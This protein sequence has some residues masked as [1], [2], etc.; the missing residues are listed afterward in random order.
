M[1]LYLPEPSFQPTSRRHQGLAR[2]AASASSRSARA[3]KAEIA[4]CASSRSWASSARRRRR[5]VGGGKPLPVQRVTHD[6]TSPRATVTRHGCRRLKGA[7]DGV[8]P[9]SSGSMRRR[10]RLCG[11]PSVPLRRPKR[12]SRSM[13]SVLPGD[14]VLI[15]AI[16]AALPEH[17]RP[18]S[19]ATSPRPPP[20]AG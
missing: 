5:G 10:V 19:N 17:C 4:L 12:V 7:A 13:R 20:A 14:A 6:V 8:I 1:S 18:L 11:R 15:E 16:A 2:P 3:A 9:A